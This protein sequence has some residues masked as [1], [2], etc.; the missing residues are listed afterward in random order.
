MNNTPK[1]ELCLWIVPSR[2]GKVKKFR[3]S[4]RLILVFLLTIT[5]GA[6]TFL[7]VTG[8]Y[9]RVQVL[10]IKHQLMLHSVTAQRDDLLSRTDDLN[11]EVSSLKNLNSKAQLR[12]QTIKE[13]LA[14]LKKVL[15][16]SPFLNFPEQRNRL[17]SPQG[18]KSKGIGGAEIDCLADPNNCEELFNEQ[19]SSF[20]GDISGD[21]SSEAD[22]LLVL[23]GYLRMLKALPVGLPVGAEVNSGFGF[24]R[25]P[26]HGG[27]RMHEGV[28]FALPPG[29]KIYVTAYGVVKRVERDGTYGLLVDVEH[30]PNLVTRYAHMSGVNVVKGQ[31]LSRGQLIGY[32]GST[33]RSTGPHLHYEV[34]VDNRAQNP[35]RFIEM[36]EKLVKAVSA[37]LI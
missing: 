11:V 3:F 24:R 9:A 28:D 26:F 29:S 33:G 20:S 17:A 14:E 35:K 13:K 21:G 5:A 8:D 31:R 1:S 23:E 12:E 16:A 15:E 25:S 27:I 6:G 7:F 36:G 2:S 37:L 32:V 22:L 10:R 30:G 4:L 34:I 19:R 18:D